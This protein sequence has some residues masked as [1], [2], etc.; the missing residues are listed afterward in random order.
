[1]RTNGRT[2]TH[3][4]AEEAATDVSMRSSST[5][6]KRILVFNKHLPRN[7]VHALVHKLHPKDNPSLLLLS[8]SLCFAARQGVMRH[9]CCHTNDNNDNQIFNLCNK[10]TVK[11]GWLSGRVVYVLRSSVELCSFSSLPFVF[12]QWVHFTKQQRAPSR[13]FPPPL[14]PPRLQF[15]L[16]LLLS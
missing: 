3:I 11:V 6:K 8:S 1:M 12:V 5:A 7:L 4:L 10:H 16:L 14:Q 15:R 13:F 9:S 2:R